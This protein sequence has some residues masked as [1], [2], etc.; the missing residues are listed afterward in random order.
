MAEERFAVHLDEPLA[1]RRNYDVHAKACGA[2]LNLGGIS[3]ACWLV[4]I[5]SFSSYTEHY[6]V[7]HPHH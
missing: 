5:P 1:F 3:W 2:W 6:D 4:L 7:I